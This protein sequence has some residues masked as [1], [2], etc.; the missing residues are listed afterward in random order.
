MYL[1][2]QSDNTFVIGDIQ[3]GHPFPGVSGTG[4]IRGD[5]VL[6]QV[7][8]T[9]SC[10]IREGHVMRFRYD[11]KAEDELELSSEQANYRRTLKRSR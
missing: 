10:K 3:N 1:T 6:L 8:T 2:L 7:N 4:R 11:L 9:E 5:T